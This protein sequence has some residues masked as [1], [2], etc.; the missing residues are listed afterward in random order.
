MQK[1]ANKKHS[2]LSSINLYKGKNRNFIDR[3][4]LWTLSAGRLI[5]ILTEIVALS[6]FL[7]RF[8]LDRNLIDL[9][10]KIKNEETILKYLQ[11]NEEKFRNIQERLSSIDKF[12]NM[13]LL[14]TSTLNGFIASLPPDMSFKDIQYNNKKLDMTGSVPTAS[15]LSNFVKTLKTDPGIKSVRL[16]RIENKI[17]N[18][19]IV[20][21][22]SILFN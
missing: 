21:S 8:S 11:K 1:T 2:R 3:F 4:I 7:Y 17:S 19:T 13:A 22:I 15:S 20:F 5:I 10:D 9:N 6:A 18:S 12:S 14:T 16:G